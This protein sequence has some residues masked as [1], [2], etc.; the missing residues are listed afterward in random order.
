MCLGR[1]AIKT[2]TRTLRLSKYLTPALPA[3]PVAIDWTNGITRWGMMLNDQLGDCTIAGLAHAVQVWTTNT[4]AEVTLSDDTVKNYYAKWDGYVDGDADTDNGG[5]ELDVLTDWRKDSFDGHALLGFADPTPANLEEIRQSITLFGGVYIGLALPLT[6]Q[7]QEVWDV[8]QDG[9]GNAQAGSWGGHCV[10]VPK[11]DENGFTC[12]TWGELKTMT[13][14]FW[15]FYC[16][17]A[18]TLLGQDW[19]TAKGSPEGF[20]REQLEADLKAIR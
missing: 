13:L 9:G 19:L 11:Y 4:G 6:A 2:D 16:D 18:H 14:D 3:P 12:I 15:K 10:Y 20:D 8:V 5:N 7:T 1:K 17:E